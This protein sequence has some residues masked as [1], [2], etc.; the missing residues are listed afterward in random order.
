MKVPLWTVGDFLDRAALVYQD[1]TAIVDE[2][3]TDGS[4]GDSPYG[5][6]EA[7]AR[8]MALALDQIG[9]DE[10]ERVAIVSP[11]LSPVPDLFLWGE[12]LW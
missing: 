4:L 7:R 2:P 3:G 10:N 12:R 5:E 1:R 6:L 8:G 11:E 9:I